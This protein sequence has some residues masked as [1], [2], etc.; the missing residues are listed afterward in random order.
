L[1]IVSVAAIG[2]VVA[3]SFQQPAP[4]QPTQ[5]NQPTPTGNMMNATT[6][7]F[8]TY[9]NPTYGVTIQY[10]SDWIKNETMQGSLFVK[11]DSS[12][13]YKGYYI[14]EV[15]L[16][17]YNSPSGN[18]TDFLNNEINSYRKSPSYQNL[19]IADNNTNSTL[20]GRPAYRVVLT[21]TNPY[22]GIIYTTIETGTIIGSKVYYIHSLVIA[23]QY[24]N[25]FP[26]IQK[27]IDS[28]EI[29]PTQQSS[30]NVTN[31]TADGGGGNATS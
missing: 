17:T 30:S 11:F 12:Q 31:A 19:I 25:Y 21:A 16:G 15:R 14:A 3:I 26:I 23:D 7:Q 29:Q 28:L 18:L 1:P 6:Q 10:P 22:S 8:P 2:I 13:A 5:Q 27:M 20:A 24:S 9:Q 4:P